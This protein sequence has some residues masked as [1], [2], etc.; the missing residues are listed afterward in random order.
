MGVKLFGYVIMGNHCHL[1]LQTTTSPL[2]K[3]MHR[4]NGRRDGES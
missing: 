3:V 2:S 4:I 1:I